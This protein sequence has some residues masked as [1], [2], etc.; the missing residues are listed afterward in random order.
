MVPEFMIDLQCIYMIHHQPLGAAGGGSS[1]SGEGAG[2]GSSTFSTVTAGTSSC[3]KGLAASSACSLSASLFSSSFPSAA[4]HIQINT[5]PVHRYLSAII[6][7]TQLEKV[8][9]Q[10]VADNGYNA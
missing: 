5:K 1:T 6:V 3:G 4:K 2:A 10:D 9:P 7:G 8:T